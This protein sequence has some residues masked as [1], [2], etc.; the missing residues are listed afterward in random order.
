MPR[1]LRIQYPSAIYHVVNRGGRGEPIFCDDLDRRCFLATLGEACEKTGW[2]IHAYVLMPDH[3]HLIIET[4]RPNLGTGM[5]WLL[6]TYTTR[7]NLRHRRP[8]QLFGSRYKAVVVDGSAAGYFHLACDYVHLNPART[9]LLRA[10][11]PLPAYSWSSWPACLQPPEQ[12]PRWLRVDRL[13]AALHIPA[14]D[15]AGRQQLERHL[16]TQR[17]L[18]PDD[19]YQPLRRGWYFGSDPFRRELLARVAA[20]AAPAQPPGPVRRE[21]D[22]EQARRLLAEELENLGWLESELAHRPKSDPGKIRIAQRL[23]A[24]TAVTLK[25]IATHLHM[26]VWTNVSNLLSAQRQAEARQQHLI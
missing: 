1:A 18:A 2:H 11:Q 15:A 19:L 14:D 6:G 7:F 24:E 9:R 8:G 25:W 20:A 23:R 16:D 5:K 26:G 21:T 12:R 10:G 17:L 4:P 3:F 13:L 22:A